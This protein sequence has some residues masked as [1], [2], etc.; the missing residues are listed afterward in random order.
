MVFKLTVFS[1]EF[2]VDAMFDA[3]PISILLCVC[4]QNIL[5]ILIFLITQ[6]HQLLRIVQLSLC[7][8]LDSPP[9]LNF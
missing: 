9:V 2:I 3:Q 6:L 4:V 8:R 1:Q 7:S 5:G